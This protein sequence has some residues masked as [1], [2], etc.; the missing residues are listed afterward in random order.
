M[1]LKKNNKMINKMLKNKMLL[2][3]KMNKFHIQKCN[4]M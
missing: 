1:F 3:F 4:Y 2:M